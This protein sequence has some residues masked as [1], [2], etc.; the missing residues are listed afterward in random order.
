MTR[1]L[2]TSLGVTAGLIVA[3]LVAGGAYMALKAPLSTQPN[4]NLTPEN[5]A[6][7]PCANVKGYTIWISNV[8]V[9]NDV[10][11]MTVKFQNSSAATH[12]SPEDLQL[13]DA[14]RRS[15][16]PITDAAGC[17]SFARHEFSSSELYGPIDICF[18]VTNS[19]PPFILHWTPD[20]GA[21]C[22]EKDITIW[23]T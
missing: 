15:S 21:F 6:P 19:N 17:K 12:A 11:R 5:C 9:Q 2:L 23:P 20:L 3:A 13:I 22:C 18:R 7:G 8:R 1:R 16:I 14:G 10:V 4:S